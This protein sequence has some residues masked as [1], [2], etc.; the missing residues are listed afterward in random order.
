MKVLTW[1]SFQDSLCLVSL[2]LSNPLQCNTLIN[3]NY[4]V[5]VSQGPAI[6]NRIHQNNPRS[7]Q[8][9][10]DYLVFSGNHSIHLSSWLARFPLLARGWITF[11]V[12]STQLLSESWSFIST[13]SIE[14][15][16]YHCPTVATLFILFSR[17]IVLII[18]LS[19][20]CNLQLSTRPVWNY[21][22]VIF[23]V[24]WKWRLSDSV[25]RDHASVGHG[26]AVKSVYFKLIPILSMTLPNNLQILTCPMSWA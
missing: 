9:F 21:V 3:S 19:A 2:V 8:T 4:A 12:L 18:T 13:P 15:S 5:R 11:F 24:L 20:A 14:T 23:E 16:Y 17:L 10:L 25:L 26:G 22:V 6:R 7:H 1:Q